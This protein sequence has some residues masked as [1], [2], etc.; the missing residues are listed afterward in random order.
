LETGLTGFSTDSGLNFYKCADSPIHPPLG[1]IKILSPGRDHPSATPTPPRAC[2]PQFQTGAPLLQDRR[3]LPG[4]LPADRALQG[5]TPGVALQSARQQ[6]PLPLP[7]TRRPGSELSPPN[8]PPLLSRRSPLHGHNSPARR[9]NSHS[10][11]STE[12][13]AG[14]SPRRD[15]SRTSIASHW[16][17]AKLKISSPNRPSRAYKRAG[18]AP[19]LAPH[20]HDQFPLLPEPSIATTSAAP[21]TTASSPTAGRRS[22]SPEHPSPR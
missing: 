9:V 13:P 10:S 1:D 16:S 17:S 15:F 22:A 20:L 3:P 4:H 12:N 6:R 18:P 2:R 8:R 5:S 7:D 21:V 14:R 19:H 11:Q